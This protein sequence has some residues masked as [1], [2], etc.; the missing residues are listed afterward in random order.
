MKPSLGR[1]LVSE[2]LGSTLL[3]AAVVGSGIMAEKLAAG[4]IALALLANSIAT[5]AAL[6]AIILA[7]ESISGPHL[8]PVVTIADAFMGGLSWKE[9]PLYIAVQCAGAIVGVIATHAMFGLPLLAASTHARSGAA[10]VFSEFVA[11]FGLLAV[12]WG[13][14]RRRPAAT[15]FA[16]GA[17]ITAA[18]W[19]TSSTSFAN[20]AVT[21]ARCL[22][23]TFSGIRPT[24]AV[25]FMAAQLI[26]AMSATLVFRW[27][28]PAQQEAA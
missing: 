13:C 21:L 3:L 23:D 14:V 25:P 9:V 27:L 12:I 4:N 1:R 28:L 15:P 5:G 24:D 8:N 17:Y 22:T 7:L 2:F 20:P 19:F 6:V 26:G 10:Q 18:Y 16:V 11:S